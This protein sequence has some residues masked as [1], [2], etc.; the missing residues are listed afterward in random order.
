M[1]TRINTTL[2]GNEQNWTFIGVPKW[3]E[4]HEGCIYTPVWSYPNFNRDPDRPPSSYA[5]ELAREDY[6]LLTSCP[7]GDTDISIDYKCPYGSVI[8][9]GIVFRAVDSTRMYVLNI[10]D[11]G[12]KGHYYELTLWRQDASGYR[13]LLASGS[14][15]HSIVSESIVQMGATTRGQWHESSPDWV[16]VRVQASGTYIRVSM[17]DHIVFDL[18]DRTYSVGYVGLVGRGA[19]YFKNFCVEGTQEELREDWTVHE[20]EMPRFFYPGQKQADGFHAYPVAGRMNDGATLV[21]WGHTPIERKPWHST[22]VVFTRSDDEGNSWSPLSMI[23]DN[24]DAVCNPTSL[25]AHN[26]GTVSCFIRAW[27]EGGKTPANV[28]IRSTDGGQNWSTRETLSLGGHPLTETQ[29]LYSPAIRLS[30]GTVVMCGY[31]AKVR[32]GGDSGSN[33]DRLD[34]SL[35]LRSTDDGYTWEEPV[36]F[37][38]DNFDHNEC[39][40]AE[41]EPG[42]L[43]AFMRTLAAPYMW[44]SKSVDYGLTWTRLEQ[45]TVSAECP[46]LLKHSSG[47]LV[48][49]S[50]GGGVFLRLSFDAGE[51]WS[52]TYRMS[53]ASAMMAMVEMAD[54][55]VLNV[56]HEGYRVPSNMRGQ[57]FTITAEGPQAAE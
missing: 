42:K 13:T 4:D 25:F 34:Q 32:P 51:T 1:N 55:R 46:L 54:A 44:T 16:T 23:F 2:K 28:V 37:D 8:H 21:A 45:T 20:G 49:G 12:R 57:Y 53:P 22:A 33:A 40:V 17:D 11:L 6:A 36:Y 47:A 27:P 48:L 15:P 52:T 38:P 24:G 41:I 26:D 30:D 39:M 7:L 50:R 9:G 18:R 31:D 29:G 43:V 14:E 35:F 56:M 3:N 10:E 5:H 19:V